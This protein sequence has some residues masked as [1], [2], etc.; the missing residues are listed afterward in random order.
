MSRRP[1]KRSAARMPEGGAP[2]PKER[3]STVGRVQVPETPLPATP[4]SIPGDIRLLQH[5]IS[6]LH[7]EL[8]RERDRNT[9]LA[10]VIQTALASLPPLEPLPAVEP[11]SRKSD[12]HV[13]MLDVSD[14]HIGAKVEPSLT[15]GLSRYDFETFKERGKRLR[16]G[17]LRIVD[18]HR[19]AYPVDVLHLNFLGDM[20]EGEGI[21]RGQ[22]FQIDKALTEQVLEGA[23]WFGNLIRDLARRFRQVHVRCVGGNHGRGYG[24]GESHPKTNWDV[25]TYRAMARLLDD[26]KN[27]EFEIP[28]TSYLVFHVSGHERFRHVLIHGDQARAWMGV[29][30]YGVERAGARL[31]SMLGLSL[32]YVHA[33]H[34]HNEA[35]W[36]SNRVE[37]FLNGS[38][39]GGSDLS[40]NKLIRTSRPTQNLFFLHPRRGLVANYRIQLSDWEEL[41][42]DEKGVYRARA[43][44]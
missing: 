7:S 31:Q 39:V 14:V 19:R 28:D 41:E 23:E 5:E 20:V 8:E 44:E 27:V 38:W 9:L 37:F 13:A 16:H 12:P 15:G 22:G 4:R 2:A 34:H 17:I 3:R 43:S 30:F 33:G 18:I 6:R 42:A 25:F 40:V 32:D 11:A 10:G 35:D 26:H 36:P 1:G 21:F 29:P 24:R